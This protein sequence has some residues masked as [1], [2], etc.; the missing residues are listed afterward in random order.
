MHR[1][2]RQLVQDVILSHRPVERQPVLMARANQPDVHA[3]LDLLPLGECGQA[4]GV[5][6]QL[7][8]LAPA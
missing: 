3:Q 7:S 6:L 8:R 5:L 4:L 1:S 2:L